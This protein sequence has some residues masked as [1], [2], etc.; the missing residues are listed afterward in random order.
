MFVHI[1]GSFTEFQREMLRERTKTG[2]DTAR[3]EGRIGGRRPKLTAGQQKEIA[4][5][6]N[7]GMKTR[8]DV[9]RLFR[10]HPSTITRL[11]AKLNPSSI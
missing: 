2:L 3:R 8:A 6:V 10:V 11:L 7:S 4:I 5:L 1:V 9:A